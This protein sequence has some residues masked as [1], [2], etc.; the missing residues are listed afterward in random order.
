MFPF[1]ERAGSG[2]GRKRVVYAGR[3]ELRKGVENLL[4]AFVPLAAEDP[5]LTLMLFGRDCA[6][7]V[8]NGMV[9]DVLTRR[10]IPE[11]LRDR[12][13]FEGPVAREELWQKYGRATLGVVPSLWEPF[14]YVCQEMMATGLPVV[15]TREGGMAEMIEHGRSGLLCDS[16]PS[17]IEAALRQAL[18]LPAPERRRMGE[19][20]ARRIRDYCDNDRVIER[21]VALFGEL[22]ARC[23]AHPFGARRLAVPANLPFGARRLADPHPKA[24]APGGAPANVA[25]VIPCYNTGEYLDQSIASLFAQDRPPNQIVV[26]NDGSTAEPTLAALDSLRRMDRVRV[27]DFP[28]GGL[29]VARNRGAEEAL[30][31]GADA[32]VFLDSDD[33]LRPTYL[34][35]AADVLGRHPEAGAVTAWTRTVG[36]MNTW[37]CPF[38][39]QFPYLL[40]DCM[41]TPP[42]MVRAAV[43]RETGGFSPDMRYAYED[44]DFWISVCERGYAMLVIPEPLIV[45]RMREGSISRVYKAATREHGRRTMM[46]RH[47][48]IFREYGAVALLLAESFLYAARGGFSG[49]ADL[50]T[51][52][53]R[54]QDFIA[55]L[56]S[57]PGRPIEA[58]RFVL[59]K[60]ADRIARRLPAVCRARNLS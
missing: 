19:A 28:N 53:R 20:A 24:G 47:P 51:E 52:L 18:A 25:V 1:E 54:C 10:L 38:H 22:K 57:L 49:S 44:W 12:I 36:L 15:A 59:G 7:P 21:T 48:A 41:S 56:G 43:Y 4:R 14:G 31:Q 30:R 50:S 58:T 16:T 5:D 17:A 27:L 42:A 33:E 9:S 13:R 46:A 29:P 23:A 34:R 39:G 3:I 8:L 35:K 2:G 11:A 32:L 26:V 60:V 55:Y 45:Y 6:H 37:W 40:A